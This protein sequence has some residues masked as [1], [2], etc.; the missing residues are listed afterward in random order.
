MS[1]YKYKRYI[2]ITPIFYVWKEE[3]KPFPTYRVWLE[4]SERFSDGTTK[5]LT[6]GLDGEIKEMLHNH[7]DRT[8]AESMCGG[9]VDKYIRFYYS[10]HPDTVLVDIRI[11]DIRY[12]LGEGIEGEYDL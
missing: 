7:L 4:V 11:M 12:D 8:F 3:D 10:I 5:V 6:H 1:H 9:V 2:E